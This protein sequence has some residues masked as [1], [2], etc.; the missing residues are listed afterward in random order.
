VSVFNSL[1]SN[2]SEADIWKHF[3]LTGTKRSLEQLE[4]VLGSH[5]TGQAAVTYKG[6]EALEL[7]LRWSG[8]P[9][10]SAVGINGFTCYV[11]YRAVERA[12][13]RPV[14]I[15]VAEHDL[16]FGL[17][18]LKA[19]R[20]QAPDLKGIIVQ[21]TLGY[22]ADMPA[23][24]AYC[25]K[26]KLM[27]IEDLAHSFGAVY[28]DGREAGT[29]GDLAMLSFSQDKPLDVVAG[30][31]VIERR[32]DRAHEAVPLKRVS[33]RQ[34]EINRDYPFWTSMIR[35]G[36]T[37]VWGRML[38]FGLKRLHALATPMGDAGPGIH[39]MSYLTA[40]LILSRW[41]RRREE[42]AHRRQ[43]AAIY[44][45]HLPK[46]LLLKPLV[47]GQPAYLRFPLWVENRASLIAYLRR[48][49]IYVSD[50]WYDAPVAPSRYLAK[51]S[52]QA[53]ECPNG[54]ALSEHIVN[55]PTHRQVTPGV[56]ADICAKIKQWQ[57]LQPKT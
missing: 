19:A 45:A 9:P 50:T 15:D 43:I 53:G 28:A 38:H 14:F 18:E 37:L 2:Y 41:E 47:S 26:H 55:L 13:Y 44:E 4:G 16:H 27:I 33:W 35:S 51:T 56:A 5:Y 32:P 11:V 48:K 34:L 40:R 42:T 31:A 25:R 49:R 30:G 39:R 54:E 23:L 10:G 8:L 1:G 17:A 46:D 22:P 52:Y 6:R 21:N 57:A 12:G 20:K 36:Y 24:S 3:L 29:V 7:A